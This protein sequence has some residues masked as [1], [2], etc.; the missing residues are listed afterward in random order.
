MGFY[1]YIWFRKDGTPYYVGKGSGRRVRVSCKRHR[2]PE[3]T[4]TLVQFWR[5][6]ATAFE[7]EKYYIRLFGRKN[8]GTGILRNLTDGGEGTSGQIFSEATREIFREVGR[9]YGPQNGKLGGLLGGRTQGRNNVKN[10]HL[11][12]ISCSRSPKKLAAAAA[13]VAPFR[14]LGPHVRWHVNRGITSPDCLF[15]EENH[16]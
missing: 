1:T 13:N 12:R 10:G 15:C 6:E 4:R 5:D 3:R 8:N 2:P 9:E 7:I 16:A 14:P 11:Q